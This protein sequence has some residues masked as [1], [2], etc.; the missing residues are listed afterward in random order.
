MSIVAATCR[1]A[2]ASHLLRRDNHAMLT[3]VVFCNWRARVLSSCHSHIK[4]FYL[5]VGAAF[6]IDPTYNLLVCQIRL[7]PNTLVF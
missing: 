5:I 3:F 1:I 7:K 6:L 4:K 2:K